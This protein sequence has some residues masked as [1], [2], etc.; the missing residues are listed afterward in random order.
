MGRVV[1]SLVVELG[2]LVLVMW[3]L[4]S[5][6]SVGVKSSVTRLQV[7]EQFPQ[8]LETRQSHCPNPKKHMRS[9]DQKP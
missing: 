7:L 4:R 8:I 9:L 2:A 1:V 3:H 5:S 6:W